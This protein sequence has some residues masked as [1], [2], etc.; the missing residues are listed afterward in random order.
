MQNW[1][2]PVG[3]PK[4]LF[5]EGR[6]DELFFDAF[7]RRLGIYD[8]QIQDCRGKDN[9][10]PLL[11]AISQDTDF[12]LVQSIGIVRDADT[13]AA[14]AFQ[15]VQGS[16]R[17]A[18]L[19]VPNE[20]L[21]ASEGSPKIAVF[22]MPDNSAGGALEDLCLAT[23]EGDP[24]MPCVADFLQ[25]VNGVVETPPQNVAKARMHAFL[26]S[27]EDSELRLGEAAQRGYLPWGNAAFESLT[28]F[29]TNL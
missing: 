21:V 5:V 2:P 1:L 25:C 19:S 13:S 10:G 26:A 22:V 16:L 4:Q 23:L 17:N 11:E 29:L 3:R 9:L 18:G 27:R 6:Q 28:E 24:A 12:H 20:M 8:V 14:S 7:M 15:S